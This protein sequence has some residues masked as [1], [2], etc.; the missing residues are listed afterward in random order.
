MTYPIPSDLALMDS[1]GDGATDRIYVGDTGGQLW[2]VDIGADRTTSAA[3]KATV[4]KLATVADQFE[5]EDQRKFFYPPDVL[6]VN[7]AA[8]SSVGNYDLVTI[9]TGNRSHPLN[10]DVQ[11]RFYAFRDYHQA[12]L[13][14]GDDP[15]P[16]P[17]ESD[18]DGLADGY[19]TLQGKT[20]ALAGNLFD[21]TDINDP[22][23]TDLTDLKDDDGYFIDLEGLGEKGLSSPITLAGTVFFTSYTPEDVLQI[24]DCSLAE[25]GGTVYAFNVLNGAAVF[26][27]WDGIGDDTNLLLNDRTQTL[28]AGIPSSAVPI[29]QKEGISLLIGGGG[30]AK[31][32]DPGLGW[33]PVRTYWGQEQ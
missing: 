28:G 33:A 16:D 6:Q 1:N 24:S 23:G 18:D 19:T 5:T 4:G 14:D 26:I 31:T 15:A 30:G 2:R 10:T 25:G 9:A 12:P 20:V 27:N 7:D 11:D 3:F 21:V 13:V 29:F 17:P 22:A 32:I 8:Y